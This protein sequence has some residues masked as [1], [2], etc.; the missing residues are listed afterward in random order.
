MQEALR[1]YELKMQKQ[2]MD[3]MKELSDIKRDIEKI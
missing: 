1:R 2:N 3:R